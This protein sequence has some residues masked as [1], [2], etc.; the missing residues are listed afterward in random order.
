M[1]SSNANKYKTHDE[2][3]V[4]SLIHLGYPLDI[5]I[6]GGSYYS[7]SSNRKRNDNTDNARIVYV[8]YARLLA[9]GLVQSFFF[10]IQQGI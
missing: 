5:E 7:S 9:S 6:C 8:Y 1:D 3:P 10:S 4:C 2:L